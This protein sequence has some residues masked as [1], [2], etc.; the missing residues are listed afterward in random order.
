MTTVKVLLY[1][2]TAGGQ[3]QPIPHEFAS[4][5]ECIATLDASF[6]YQPKYKGNE[7]FPLS[8]V[9]GITGTCILVQGKK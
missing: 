7:K 4:V 5:E 6:L 3:L 8:N 1:L 2:L 9:E